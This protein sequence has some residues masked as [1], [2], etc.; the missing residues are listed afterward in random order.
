MGEKNERELVVLCSRGL[1][2]ERCIVAWTIANVA[3]KSGQAVTMFLVSAGVDAVRKGAAKHMQ[4]NPT[5]PPL[6]ELVDDFVARRGTIFV[7]PPCA[8]Y[9]GYD[10][11]SFIDGVEIMGSLPMHEKLKAG[12]AS[13][14]F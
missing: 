1:D 4:L 9:R 13:L 5:D 7:C 8:E 14:S 6:Q 12:A 10:A 2:D 3:I 11:A